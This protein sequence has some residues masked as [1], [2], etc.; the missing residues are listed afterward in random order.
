M[1]CCARRQAS[2]D[3]SAIAVAARHDPW[4]GAPAFRCAAK[5]CARHAA[6]C[7][8]ATPAP[9]AQN[10]ARL[11]DTSVHAVRVEQT[12]SLREARS[13][14]RADPHSGEC[15]AVRQRVVPHAPHLRQ[16]VGRDGVASGAQFRLR[17]GECVVLSRAGSQAPYWHS[18]AGH[19]WVAPG[20][21][22]RLRSGECVVLP[23]ARSQAPY[24][25]SSAGHDWVAPG[26]R[27]RLLSSERGCVNRPH[28][29]DLAGCAGGAVA[30]VARDHRKSSR[31]Q[32]EQ[33]SC[34]VGVLPR[35]PDRPGR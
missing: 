10:L 4:T 32:P 7:R 13:R 24:W 20:V 31:L 30:C 33:G 22:Y 23:R 2:L 34:G 3:A 6:G 26:V 35:D 8:G 27:Y 1:I 15:V 17:S 5:L 29:Q 14:Q 11:P 28:R 21:R 12:Q 25:H 16:A 19:D 18:P 9:E